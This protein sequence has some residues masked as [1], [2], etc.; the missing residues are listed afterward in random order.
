MDLGCALIKKLVTEKALEEV[1]QEPTMI[2]ALEKR[3]QAREKNEYYVDQNAI[4]FAAMLPE[5]LR[6]ALVGLSTDQ[7]RIYEDFA[8]MADDKKKNNA[9]SKFEFCKRK[10]FQP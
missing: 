8:G 2:E 1:D 3:R 10:F 9:V 5:A 6:P 4:K 7:L